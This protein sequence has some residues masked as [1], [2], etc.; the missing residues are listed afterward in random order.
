MAEIRRDENFSTSGLSTAALAHADEPAQQEEFTDE[1]SA[2][3]VD[4]R[5]DSYSK[6][7]YD[8]ADTTA[9]RANTTATNTTETD[10]RTALFSP[11]ETGTLRSQ[12][13]AIQVGFVDEPRQA[14]EKADA[15][16]AGAMK[17]LAEVFA[18]ERERLEKQWDRGDSVS[19]EELRLALRR[20]RAFFGRLLSV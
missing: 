6:N 15:L 10:E 2:Q 4:G 17:R 8:R 16:V 13:D 1:R 3:R 9:T 19:T 5:P 20:Y 11:D 14:V 7:N 18:A 12:W